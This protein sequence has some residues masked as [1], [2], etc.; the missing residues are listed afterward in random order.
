MSMTQQSKPSVLPNGSVP[1]DQEQYAEA[2]RRLNDVLTEDGWLA[3]F[4]TRLLD[5]HEAGYIVTPGD[6]ERPLRD[7]I[8]EFTVKMENAIELLR[9]TPLALREQ[10]RAAVERRP[11]LLA[12]GVE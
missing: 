6:A 12:D 9:D 2:H 7:C 4:V 11:E 10:I 1:S 5:D 8:D 3:G